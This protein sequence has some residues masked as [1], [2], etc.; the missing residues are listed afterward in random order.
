MNGAPRGHNHCETLQ[1]AGG[2]QMIGIDFPISSSP[3]DMLIRPN[4]Q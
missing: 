1:Y 4:L 3:I 2:R